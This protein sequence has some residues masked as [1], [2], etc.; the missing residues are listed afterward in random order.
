VFGMMEAM[1]SFLRRQIGLRTDSAST[2]G[3]LHAKVANLINTSASILNTSASIL[4]KSNIKSIQRGIL[5]MSDMDVSKNVTISSVNTAKAMVNFLGAKAANYN[6]VGNYAFT[7]TS[8]HFVTL[9]L[10]NSTTITISRVEANRQ[11]TV[12]WEVIEFY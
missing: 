9:E 11:V 12:S 5:V 1:L 10:V 8:H 6:T 3:S 7:Y 2:S 4:N